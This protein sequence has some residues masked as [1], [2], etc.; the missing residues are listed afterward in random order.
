MQKK[1]AYRRFVQL[2]KKNNWDDLKV[3]ELRYFLRKGWITDEGNLEFSFDESVLTDELFLANENEKKHLMQVN[4]KEVIACTEEN[5]LYKVGDTEYRVNM[6][7][8]RLNC[9]RRMRKCVSCGMECKLAFLD[10]CEN[11]VNPHVNIY[12]IFNG[13][14][15]YTVLMTKDHIIPKSKGGPDHDSNYQTM[16]SLCNRDKGSKL[17]LEELKKT[18][19]VI[20]RMQIVQG[21]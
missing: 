21:N 5:R 16:C 18:P 6:Q 2:T 15:H 1:E 14:S 17:T 10:K 11:D 19:L 9:F 13:E 7:S 20:K 12:G 8:G 4:F 3:S